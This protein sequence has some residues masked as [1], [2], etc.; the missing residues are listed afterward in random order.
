[1]KA[2]TNPIAGFRSCVKR[3]GVKNAK[4]C[5]QKVPDLSEAYIKNGLAMVRC[6]PGSPVYDICIAPCLLCILPTLFHIIPRAYRRHYPRIASSPSIMQ[7]ETATD[8]PATTLSGFVFV[9]MYS[10]SL[11]PVSKDRTRP[12][13]Q[14][15]LDTNCP[16]NTT[17]HSLPAPGCW[18]NIGIV[19][20]LYRLSVRPSVSLSPSRPFLPLEK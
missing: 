1:M 13:I 5:K 11:H 19:R 7:L 17:N 18:W 16:P 6:F 2:K 15:S 3:L 4:R 8:R 20:A 12:P 10:E 14:P 9:Y